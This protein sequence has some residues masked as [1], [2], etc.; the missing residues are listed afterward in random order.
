M[1]LSLGAEGD[2]EGENREGRRRR[3]MYE[4]PHYLLPLL[5]GSLITHP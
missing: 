3:G 2:R 4:A 5:R 1:Q